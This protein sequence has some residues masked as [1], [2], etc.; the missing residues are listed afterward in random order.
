[1][2]SRIGNAMVRKSNVMLTK[3]RTIRT[4]LVAYSLE[5]IHIV[6]V[7]GRLDT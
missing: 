7:N 1:M 3:G 5:G 2:K 4:I 6:F